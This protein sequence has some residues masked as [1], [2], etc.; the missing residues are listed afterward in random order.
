MTNNCSKNSYV[1]AYFSALLKNLK[2]TEFDQLVQ[3]INIEN[4]NEK[5]LVTLSCI[6][7]SKK[8]NLMIISEDQLKNYDKIVNQKILDSLTNND[9][10]S[11]KDSILLKQFNLSL[12][13]SKLLCQ[14]YCRNLEEMEFEN[15]FSDVL[16][17][18]K[19]L[20][21]RQ[22]LMILII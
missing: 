5:D 9:I 2:G 10:N 12:K 3:N 1:P 7:T 8:N 4:L 11:Y 20:Y 17:T 15:A 16:K 18:I 6:L 13:E 19:K 14:K 22:I 21:C